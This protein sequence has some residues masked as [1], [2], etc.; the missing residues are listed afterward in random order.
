MSENPIQTHFSEKDF[1][2]YLYM[3]SHEEIFHSLIWGPDDVFMTWLPLHLLI[4]FLLAWLYPQTVPTSDTSLGLID[5][6][7]AEKEKVIPEFLIEQTQ[8]Y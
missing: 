7:V 1:C 2:L 4:L 3:L 5:S 6:S 8:V